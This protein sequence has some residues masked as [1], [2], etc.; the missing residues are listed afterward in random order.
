VCP[1]VAHRG[2]SDYNMESLTLELSG[3]HVWRVPHSCHVKDLFVEVVAATE[4]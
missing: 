4:D 2:L 3:Y 1:K